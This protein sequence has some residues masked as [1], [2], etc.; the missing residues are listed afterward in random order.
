MIPE[1]SKASRNAI[2]MHERPL[3]QNSN[4]FWHRNKATVLAACA[5]AAAL[6]TTG[7]S[8]LYKKR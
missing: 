2:P 6:V 4:S 7:I 1:P 3:S 5:G 8:Y